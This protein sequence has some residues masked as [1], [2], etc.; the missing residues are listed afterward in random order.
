M[1]L[2]QADTFLS[3]DAIRHNIHRLH[4]E[5]TV[6]VVTGV[7]VALC[8][9]PLRT[10]L[11]CLTAVKLA[12]KL[13]E[14]HVAAVPLL[15]LES[16]KPLREEVPPPLYLD[17][18]GKIDRMQIQDPD[19]EGV[20]VGGGGQTVPHDIERLLIQAEDSLGEASQGRDIIEVLKNTHVPGENLATAFGRFLSRLLERWGP[21]LLDPQDANLNGA[22]EKF[23]VEAPNDRI[24]VALREQE[25]RL[26]AAGY[27][28]EHSR[29]SARTLYLQAAILP[30]VVY[31]ADPAEYDDFANASPLH[32]MFGLGPPM[33]WPRVSATLIDGRCQKL[34][35]KYG[36]DLKDLFQGHESVMRRLS[37]EK[38]SHKTAEHFDSLAAEIQGGLSDLVNALPPEDRSLDEVIEASKTKMLYQISKLKEKFVASTALR[39]ETMSRHVERLCNTLAPNGQLQEEQLGALH[40]L[41]R[42]SRDFVEVLYDRLEIWKLEHQTIFLD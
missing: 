25:M 10:L 27:R 21:V 32:E 17:R 3:G 19:P 30:T 26:A 40:F 2:K 16:G 1:L 18:E 42:Y 37:E 23:G 39:H 12:A 36:L 8:G 24:Q 29:A 13:E 33:V 28:A 31:V 4:G 11:K 7:P 41:L 6:A 5:E 14:D 38:L 9:G 20:P 22:E 15:R 34:L 35:H